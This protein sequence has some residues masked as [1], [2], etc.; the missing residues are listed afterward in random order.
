MTWDPA[1]YLAF[2]DHRLRPALDLIQRVPLDQVNH[3]VDLGCGAGNVTRALRDR[4]PA[5]AVT[6]VDSSE[7]MLARA[8]QTA[9]DVEWHLAD[10]AEW[11]PRAPVD[12]LFSNAALQWLDGHDRLF[13]RLAS[14]VA[15]GGVLAVQMPRNFSEPSH[16]SIYET[17]REPRW[18]DRLERLIRPEPTKPGEYYRDLLVPHARAIDIWETVYLQVLDGENPVA[19]FVKGSWLPPFLEALTIDERAAFEAAY[20]RRV[21]A[22]YTPRADGKTLFPFRRLFVVAA[23]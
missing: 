7:A 1:Q 11:E 2:G 4:W 13:P 17:A 12:L 22:A 9:A 21:Q 19:E 23:R 3:I 20:R 16:T 5:A 8:R 15:S 10:L 14:M 18:R 6:G